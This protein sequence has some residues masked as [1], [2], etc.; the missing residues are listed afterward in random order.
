MINYIIKKI[1]T[2]VL[3]VL[4]VSLFVFLFMQL[5]PGDPARIALGEAAS[6]AAIQAYRDKYG[7]DDPLLVQY[8]H[9]IT[10]IVTRWDFG[11]SVLNSRDV[12][13]YI[14]DRLPNTVS[15][16]LPA[17]VLGVIFGL[18]VGILTAIRRG[19]W[20]DQVLTF[21]V[22]FFLGVPRFLIAIF[23]VLILAVQL[24][25]IPLQGYTAPWENFGEYVHKSL[26]P[27]VVNGIFTVAMLA[28]QTRSNV[29]EAINQDYVR[30]ARANG[31]PEGSVVMKH[32]LKNALI[33]VVT[34]IGLQMRNIVSGAVIIENIF[35][36]P[37]IGQ[38]L[39]LG[40]QQ[41]DYFIVQGC[42]VVISMVTVF[43]NLI[44]DIAYGFIDPRVR[45]SMR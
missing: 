39:L 22:N 28:R 5:L 27:I 43:C 12:T 42:V 44:V 13:A 16:G 30:T 1:L 36:I 3:L 34:I 35:N 18:A 24:K 21:I 9:W 11:K 14:S 2:A 8:F 7:L 23:G 31:I 32:T 6:D 25:L 45:K 4:L 33:P 41:R 19:T 15:I 26:W 38:L 10:G 37:G 40:V 20:V 17:L 29:L